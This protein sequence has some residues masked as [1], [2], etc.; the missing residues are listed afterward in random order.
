MANGRRR[1]WRAAGA[2]LLV[3]LGIALLLLKEDGMQV[4]PLQLTSEERTALLRWARAALRAHLETGAPPSIDERSLPRAL[5]EHASCF[6]TLTDNGALRGCILDS[7][8]PHESVARNVARNVVLAATV[9]SR[10]APVVLAE[11]DRLTIEISILGQ[12]YPIPHSPPERLVASLHPGVDGVTLTTTLGTSTFLP[13]VWEQ[14]PGVEVFLSELCRKQGAPA[15][16][17]RTVDLLR[18]EIYQ[19]THFSEAD[20]G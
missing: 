4:G 15:T 9:D 5:R 8:R 16:C 13:Q 6:V 18:V 19:V 14:L 3:G 1:V 2:L 11:L 7:F 12:P 20:S 10:F 17:W